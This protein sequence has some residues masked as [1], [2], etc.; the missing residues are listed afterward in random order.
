MLGLEGILDELELDPP[1]AV[2]FRG[3]GD[4][5]FV[6]GGD[7]KEFAAIRATDEARAMATRMRDILD[8]IAGLRSVTIAELNGHALGGGAELAIACDLRIGADDVKLGF[9]QA[10]LGITPA[11]GGIERLT[12]LVGRARAIYLMGTGVAISAEHGARW[13]LIEDMIPRRDF[14]ERTHALLADLG[15]RPATVLTSIKEIVSTVAP[16]IHP[17]SANDAVDR[18]AASWVADTHWAAV[19]AAAPTR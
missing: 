10:R 16:A 7:L 3:A 12:D 4:R 19:A 18:F 15:S 9:S 11:W 8:R 14:D 17:A 2:A 5:A 1:A 6:S 13:G